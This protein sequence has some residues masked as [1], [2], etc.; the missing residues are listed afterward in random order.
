MKILTRRTVN[1]DISDSKHNNEYCY[2]H[3][4]FK[5]HVYNYKFQLL[6]SL[7]A[8]DEKGNKEIFHIQQLMQ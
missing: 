3:D 2:Y 6:T 1:Q 5:Y 8:S 4:F 7:S